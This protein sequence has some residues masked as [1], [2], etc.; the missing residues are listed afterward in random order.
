MRLSTRLTLVMVGLVLS[1]AGAIGLLTYRNLEQVARRSEL[2]R[3]RS[4]VRQL[5]SEL[6]GYVDNV[7]SDAL[8]ARKL[9]AIDGFVRA[10]NA[11]DKI[12]PQTKVHARIWAQAVVLVFYAEL[13]AKPSFLQFRLIGL[14]DEGR[15]LI[16]VDRHGKDGKIRIVPRSELQKK[17]SR[18]YVQKAKN[19]PDGS[20]YISP[21]ELN[22]EQGVIQEPHTPVMR[23][24]TPI[25]D[26]AGKIFGVIVVNVDMGLAFEK[27]RRAAHDDSHV[28]AVN[29]N[30]DYLV[31]TDRSREFRFEHGESRRW[32]DDV[33][34]LVES[35]RS[36]G[37][38]YVGAFRNATGE[39]RFAAAAPVR[40]ADERQL[41]V[42][43]TAPYSQLNAAAATARNSAIVAGLCSAVVATIL[44]VIFA[45]ATAGPLERLASSVAEFT[46][47]EL[48][49]MPATTNREVQ[50]LATAVETMAE[51]VRRKTESL[52]RQ[53][54]ESAPIAVIMVNRQGTIVFTNTMA[55]ALFGYENSELLGKQ[56]ELLVPEPARSSHAELRSGYMAAPQQRAMGVGRDL[57]GRRK[58]G[59]EFPVEIGLN[60]VD[61]DDEQWV[62]AAISDI[63][64]RKRLDDE[65]RRVKEDL[66]RR[67]V[68]RTADLTT[69]VDAL[70]KSNLEL[71]QFAYVASHDL[72]SPLRGISGFVQLLQKRYG[73]QL[74]EEA[75]NWIDRTVEAT[76]KMQT[77]INDL[78]AY[79]R[80]ENRTRPFEPVDL[81]QVFD[82]VV[83]GLHPTIEDARAEVARDELPTIAGDRSHLLQ[84]L[85]NLILNAIK[86]R[87]ERPPVVHVAAR[88]TGKEWEISVK[89]NGI[90]IAEKH[91]VQDNESDTKFAEIVRDAQDAVFSESLAGNV[92]SWNPASEKLFGFKQS[93][94]IGQPTEKIVPSDQLEE[95][96]GLRIGIVDG[97]QFPPF[98]T[99]RRHR[100]GTQI[101]VSLSMSPVF[102]QNGKINGISTIARDLRTHPSGSIT[103]SAS[104]EEAVVV[105]VKEPLD[106]EK[107]RTGFQ[108]LRRE[109]ESVGYAISHDLRAPLRAIRGFADIISRRQRNELND[110]GQRYLDNIIEAGAQMEDLIEDLLAYVRLGRRGADQVVVPLKELFSQLLR[111]HTPAIE[112]EK[113]SIQIADDLPSVL[114][115]AT[116]LYQAFGNLIINAI[117]YHH[118]SVDPI[119]DVDSYR[120]RDRV[121]V[122]IQ[123]NGIGISREYHEKIFEIFQRL[124]SPEQ[125]PGQ[126]ERILYV[127]DS[128]FDRDLVQAAL[129]TD[130]D[131]QLTVTESRSEFES[132]I[133]SEPFELVLSDFNILGFDGLQ[134]IET[135]QSSQPNV[136]VVIVTG[137][138][139]EEV[140]VE[141]MKLGAADYVI[142]SPSHIVRLP[143]TIRTVLERTR[144]VHEEERLRTELNRFFD[145]SNDML[146][147]ID[148][149]GRI[150]RANPA[151]AALLGYPLEQMYA[152]TIFDLIRPDH[153]SIVSDHIQRIRKTLDSARFA[154]HC[155]AADNAERWIEWNV[156]RSNGPDRL[157]AIGRDMT[158]Q[159][160][161]ESEERERAVAK[162]KV[163]MLT[164][165]EQQVLSLV[166]AGKANKLIAYELDLAEKTIEHHRSSGMRK[167]QLNSVPD[168][169]R[170]AMLADL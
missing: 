22:R 137:T 113:A 153:Q 123:D 148:R 9:P 75:R 114:G 13:S 27:L 12:D 72:Q 40:L 104:A 115:D 46:G 142:K 120:Y 62:L 43:E 36:Q 6:V 29:E 5:A 138:G 2:E 68:E 37:G 79:S 88:N 93:E 97:K 34:E 33:P 38:I 98:D 134:V 161:A 70:E 136:P 109:L 108:R 74:N 162:A 147:V 157:F 45:R 117:T 122:S 163:S 156:F 52:R 66:E 116:L 101:P 83:D 56:V 126:S 141:A 1:T 81:N 65:R 8:V 28:F 92:V 90:G 155:L 18:D 69:A 100:D 71:Q 168:L 159:R 135:V 140:A 23:A 154:V 89:D 95:I 32:Q 145:L 124:H 121:V 55:T 25:Y 167:L 146:L 4:R 73:D 76:Q 127:D 103:S 10:T 61:A 91:Q 60:P 16:R 51:G 19:L 14:A 11:P 125:F 80:V 39:R 86:Y 82:E 149:D 44:A 151:L 130:P 78:L 15:E 77:L 63:T 41:V 106:V 59:T 164:P 132:R 17:G 24:A 105:S 165:R 30:G 58:D 99:W 26:P 31:H 160:A 112:A 67:V 47:E 129:S 166:V 96:A 3:E 7:R 102:D 133:T 20:V 53:T 158:E 144:L 152:M 170:M 54:L 111:D 35:F 64:E 107:E 57:Y 50:E 118:P 143:L 42:V 110:Q 131:L 119:I 48:A 139:S 150:Q 87:S 128:R 49:A 169:V 84:V 85:Q 21:I 94:I